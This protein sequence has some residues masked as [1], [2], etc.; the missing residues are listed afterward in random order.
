M[1]QDWDQ[2]QFKTL[3]NGKSARLIRYDVPMVNG[4]SVAARLNALFFMEI[5]TIFSK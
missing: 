1:Y 2:L 5:A 3:V 4:G